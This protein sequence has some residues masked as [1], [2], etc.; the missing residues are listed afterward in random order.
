MSR[1]SLFRYLMLSALL[2]YSEWVTATNCSQIWTQA[3]RPNST[4]PGTIDYPAAN[5]DFPEPLANTDYYFAENGSYEIAN[6]TVRTTVGTT[7]R[8]FV[9]GNLTIGNNSEL[10]SSGPAE[11]LI[12]VVSGSLAIRNNV[13]INGFILAGGAVSI[14][15]NAVIDGA[16]TAKGAIAVGNNASVQFNADALSR[17]NGGTFCDQPLG[18]ELDPFNTANL[19]DNWVTARSS[20]NFTP[21]VVNGRLRLTQAVTNQATSVTYQRLYPATNNLVVVEFDYL[22]YGGSGADGVAV[23]LSDSAITPQPGAFGGPLGYGF[24][25]G[26]AGFAGG[27][28]GFGLDEFGNYSNEGGV[29]NVGRR[30]QSVVIRGSGS[31]TSGYR[32]LRGTCNNGT[33]NTNGNCLSPTVDGNQAN[34]HRYRFVVDSRQAG[35]TLVSVERNTGSGFVTLIAPFNAQAQTGQAPLPENFYLS[36]TGSTGGSTNIHELDNVSICALRSL[37]IGQQID[38]FEFDYSSTPLTCKAESFTVRACANPACTELVT[39]PVTATLSPASLSNG[40]WVGGNVLNFS[41]GSTTVLLQ[42]RTASNTVVG[43]SS[44]VPN[45]RPLS[46]TLCRRGNSALNTQ[47][48]TVPFA[49]SGLVFDIPDGIADRPDSAITIAAVKQ[50]DVSQQCIPEF[51]NVTRSVSFWSSYITPGAAARPVSW[52][53]RVNNTDIGSSFAGATP[54]P[55]NFDA[56]GRASINVNY[57]DAGQVE[58]NARY[59][60]TAINNDSGLVMNGADRFIRR[61]AGLCVQATSSCLSANASCPVFAVAG[62]TFPLT[63]TAHSWGGGNTNYCDNAVTPNFEHSNITLQHQLL[64]PVGALGNMGIAQY[65][66]TRNQQAQTQVNQSVTESGVFRFGT[67]AFSYLGMPEQVPVA[68]SEPIGR[69]VPANF[70][71][72]EVSLTTFSGAATCSPA[73]TPVYLRQPLD[74]RYRLTALNRQGN[75]TTNYLG[76]FAKATGVLLATSTQPWLNLTDRLDYSATTSSAWQLG[77]AD[78][79]TLKIA[80]EP[81]LWIRRSEERDGPFNNTVLALQVVDGEMPQVA[82]IAEADFSLS[83]PACAGSQ[84]NSKNVGEFTLR[85]GR[86]VLENAFGSE[87]DNLPLTLRAEYWDGERFVVN[88]DD[89]CTLSEFT[90]LNQLG[91]GVSAVAAGT[92][93]ALR[94][95]VSRPLS[96]LLNAPGVAGSTTFEY[97]APPWLSYNWDRPEVWRDDCAITDSANP[98]SKTPNPWACMIFGRYRGNPRLIFWREQ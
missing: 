92:V 58:L 32:Y 16:V 68:W 69:F 10:N 23:V 91:S 24:K 61:P 13:R 93:T 50:D 21:Q 48:C 70:R 94:A 75:I 79:A 8:L 31:N 97:L 40:G 14:S 77:S 42:N 86:L 28:L 55:L 71:I 2:V 49:A 44:S 80:N 5:P 34:P 85:Y 88:G 12:I 17:L 33:S 54:L 64:A 38:H 96:L 4:V 83:Q 56:Q 18:C 72:S 39:S 30:R 47:N 74:L 76:A 90:E 81:Q 53:I 11:N 62:D 43:V 73:I 20:G 57:A 3:I 27:W 67:S 37:P 63:I 9:N 82:G 89:N 41:G 78:F 95:G 35:A 29:T 6:N 65:N 59:S 98:S 7:T 19:S 52:P 66:H 36:L 26:I 15:N 25:P 60:G 87:F 1:A 51:S 45:T 22:A 84:C 46:Q